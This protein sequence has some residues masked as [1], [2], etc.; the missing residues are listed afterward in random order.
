MITKA[1]AFITTDG[2]THATLEDAQKA[3]LAIILRGE[4]V[5]SIENIFL[6]RDAVIAVL[7]MTP[8]SRPKAQKANGA[9]RKRKVITEPVATSTK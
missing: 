6:N 4:E 5:I 2:A 7:K 1:P 9:T 8:K 3:E